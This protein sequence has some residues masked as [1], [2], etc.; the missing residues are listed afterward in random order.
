MAAMDGEKLGPAHSQWAVLMLL[1]SVALYIVA[2]EEEE[3]ET[4]NCCSS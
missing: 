4:F 2:E 1:H 3:E